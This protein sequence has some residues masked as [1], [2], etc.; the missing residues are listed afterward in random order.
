M[1]ELSES[2]HAQPATFEVI[3]FDGREFMAVLVG[4]FE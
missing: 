4:D 2:I 3:K 1:H